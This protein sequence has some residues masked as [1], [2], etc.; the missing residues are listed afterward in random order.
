MAQELRPL[1]E[2]PRLVVHSQ[3]VEGEDEFA[4][5]GSRDPRAIGDASDTTARYDEVVL[6]RE[7]RH[8][9]RFTVKRTRRGYVYPARHFASRDTSPNLPPMG[10]RVRLKASVDITRYPPQAQVILKCLQR[11]GMI[12]ADNG[13]DWFISGAPDDRWDDEDINTIQR[14]HGSD[15]EVIKMGEVIT[16]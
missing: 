9:L 8:A 4:R 12:L 6:L 13:S 7:I 16:R 5:L 1:E 14:L 15:L 11:Y 2:R 3:T 10:M